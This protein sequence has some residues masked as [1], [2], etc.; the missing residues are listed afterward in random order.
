M[1]MDGSETRNQSSQGRGRYDNGTAS[2]G[3]A[4]RGGRMLYCSDWARSWS[5]W[6]GRQV[7]PT[8]N[9]RGQNGAQY[10]HDW[11]GQAPAGL[12]MGTNHRESIRIWMAALGLHFGLSRSSYSP[13]AVVGSEPAHDHNTTSKLELPH[14]FSLSRYPAARD[15]NGMTSPTSQ[16]PEIPTDMLTPA[17][18]GGSWRSL[19]PFL[20]RANIRGC[21]GGATGR[22][23]SGWVKEAKEL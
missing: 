14:P 23:V 16:S 17:S 9:S 12:V 8:K 20:G 1:C 5:C 21:R 6:M 22:L 15:H 10:F 19:A 3:E 18:L 7:A 11:G 13:T 2:P 4:R